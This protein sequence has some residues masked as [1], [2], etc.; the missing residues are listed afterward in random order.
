MQLNITNY[1]RII[2]LSSFLVLVSAFI[3]EFLFN[4]PPCNLCIY[5][6]VPYYFLLIISLTSLFF[7]NIRVLIYSSLIALIASMVISIFHS[8]VERKLVNFQMGCTSQQENFSNI[9]DLRNFL[10]TVPITK[11]D[12]ITF[13]IMG[14]SL[15][16]INLIIS[17]LLILLTLHCL[18]NYEKNK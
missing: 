8:L 17:F 2:L 15:A 1:F 11:C 6:R 10:D 16:N 4:H 7:N 18:I 3:I 9:E 14:F 5:Q 12:E 13:S